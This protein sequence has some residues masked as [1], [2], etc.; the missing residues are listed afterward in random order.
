MNEKDQLYDQVSEICC[1]KA[2]SIMLEMAGDSNTFE[3]WASKE[4]VYF[5][6]YTI[7][8]TQKIDHIQLCSIIMADMR[9][10]VF[11]DWDEDNGFM[12][13]PSDC[14]NVS[15]IKDPRGMSHIELELLH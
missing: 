14:Y 6:L 10:H 9:D 2:Y 4:D 11:V 3:G 1:K 12:E 5:N 7:A 13:F 8:P 15:M